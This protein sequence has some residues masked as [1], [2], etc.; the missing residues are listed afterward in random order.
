MN[1]ISI[2]VHFYFY[3]MCIF[4]GIQLLFGISLGSHF[5]HGFPGKT[6]IPLQFENFSENISICE[7]FVHFFFLI[8]SENL[9]HM[10]LALHIQQY[11]NNISITTK[12]WYNPSLDWKWRIPRCPFK[13]ETWK[14]TFQNC[15][16]YFMNTNKLHTLKGK[17]LFHTRFN[18]PLILDIYKMCSKV[19]VQTKIH[20]WIEPQ[21]NNQTYLLLWQTH[22]SLY[23]VLSTGSL[24]LRFLSHNKL[25]SKYSMSL[26]YFPPQNHP[27]SNMS[28]EVSSIQHEEKIAWYLINNHTDVHYKIKI[29]ILT[30][31]SNRKNHVK[32]QALC[33]PYVSPKHCYIELFTDGTIF[34]TDRV[35]TW[36]P[37]SLHAYH[38]K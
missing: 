3:W 36:G 15:L 26:W 16:L 27:N 38:Y 19:W 21:T 35:R 29:G 12:L 11:L 2:V 5:F 37:I 30:I 28:S 24:S 13:Y 32:C 9:W 4:I 33:Q 20:E 18:S 34:L 25:N 6:I 17:N 31:G 22:T 23:A 1:S 14:K 8:I 10:S 7:L